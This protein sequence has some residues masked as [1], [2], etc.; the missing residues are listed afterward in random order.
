MS[1][2]IRADYGTQYLFPRSLEEWVKADDPARFIRAFVRAL[3]V[4]EVETEEERAARRDPMGR[5]HYAFELL[6][7]VWL[8]GY[9]NGITSCR[10][11]EVAC[12]KELPLIWLSGTEEPDHNTLW[13]FWNKYEE[14]VGELFRRAVQVA[15]RANMVGFVLQ[16]VDGTKVRSRASRR[17]EWH[18]E[19]LEK[20]MRKLDV[21]IDRI[22]EQIKAAG[23]GDGPNERLPEQ[24]QDE[25][26][27]REEIRKHLEELA[28]SGRKDLQPHDRDARMMVN[29]RGRTEFAYN[30]QAVADENSGLIVAAAVTDEENDQHQLVPMVEQA[31]QNQGRTAETTVADSGYHTAEGLGRAE[32]E[33][34]EVVVAEKINEKKVGPY[35]ASRFTFDRE[36]DAVQCP[37]GEWLD[38]EGTRH[39][40]DKPHPLN[41]YRCHV[42]DCPV[43]DQCTR[44]RRGRVIEISPH[45]DAVQKN[46]TALRDPD[47]RALLKRRGSLIERVFAE[48]KQRLGLRRWSFAGL[49]RVEAQW[50]L[51]C[52]AFNIRRMIAAGADA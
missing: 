21:R 19:D 26:R 16:A 12:R 47:K 11:L 35:H 40:K 9:S 49:K 48:I 32:E 13:R 34:F 51:T 36:R 39:H 14:R 42:K 23:E 2:E 22:E 15:V 30:A 6:L 52:M 29:S 46:R 20:L 17:S 10:D 50:L 1:R 4:E 43:R 28:S 33:G 45:H 41:T 7:S 18:Q 37:R 25:Q 31:T 27:L 44:D 3:K 5:P 8:Y 38:R 24:L